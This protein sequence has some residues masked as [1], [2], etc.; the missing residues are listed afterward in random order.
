[1]HSSIRMHEVLRKSFVQSGMIIMSMTLLIGLPFAV[2]VVANNWT[3]LTFADG[4]EWI[5]TAVMLTAIIGTSTWAICMVIGV[6]IN[7]LIDYA[8]NHMV[9]HSMLPD[10]DLSQSWW[11][12]LGMAIEDMRSSRVGYAQQVFI[13]WPILAWVAIIER[14][15]QLRSYWQRPGTSVTIP[16]LDQEERDDVP[17]LETQ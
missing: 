3:T 6:W 12:R 5:Y 11:R 7:I 9:V 13:L 8:H 16:T 2:I 15:S 1:M 14:V 17:L 4:L 10:A